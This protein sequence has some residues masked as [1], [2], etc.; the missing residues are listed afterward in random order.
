MREMTQG[1]FLEIYR[2]L[3][4]LEKDVDIAAE[5]AKNRLSEVSDEY[6][7]AYAEGFSDGCILTIKEL[8][9]KVLLDLLRFLGVSV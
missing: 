5:D 6:A 2:A 8:K 9:E 1:T 3:D 7:D 4:E